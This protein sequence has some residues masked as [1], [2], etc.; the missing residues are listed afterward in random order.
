MYDVIICETVL[1]SAIRKQKQ[2]RVRLKRERLAY[3]FKRPPPR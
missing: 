3:L 1:D 2:K